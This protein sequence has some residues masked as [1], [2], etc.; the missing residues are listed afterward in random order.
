[1]S[2]S[3]ERSAS[4]SPVHD[5]TPAVTDDRDPIRDRQ[6][7]VHVLLGEQHA[8]AAPSDVADPLADLADDRRRQPLRRLV[9]DDQVGGWP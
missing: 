1:M 2:V 7:E 9:H 5:S 8:V 6:R 4:G 3:F